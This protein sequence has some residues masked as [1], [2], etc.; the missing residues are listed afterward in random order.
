MNKLLQLLRTPYPSLVSPWKAILIPTALIF[1]ILGVLQPFGIA[2]AK[3][4]PW[5]IA[6]VSALIAAAA[7]CA[8]NLL[9][10]TLFPDYY[11]ERRWTIGKEMLHLAGMFL[12][13]AIGVCLWVAWLTDSNPSLRLFSIALLWVLI[14]G[15]FPTVLFILWNQN[16]LLRRNLHEARELNHTL[17]TRH[18]PAQADSPRPDDM[19]LALRNG[20]KDTVQL[21]A[22]RFLYAEAEGNYVKLHSLPEAGGSPTMQLVRITMKQAEEN[23]AACPTIIRC[24]RAFLV[25]L[26]KVVKVD[27]NQQGYRL[28]L[29]GCKDE[30]P[31]S[32]AYAKKLRE[33]LKE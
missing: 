20:T 15:V 33:K 31:V 13:I 5:S 8:C 19:L 25:N 10:P 28:R 7:S 16:L 22:H 26:E 21:P 3:A 9:L 18:R 17:A 11:D 4:G 32:R 27:G 6:A 14:L 12:L 1:L 23:A 29:E 2:H 24:H 30:V